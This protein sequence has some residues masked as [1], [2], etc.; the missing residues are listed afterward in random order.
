MNLILNILKNKAKQNLIINF[1]LGILLT[2][3]QLHISITYVYKQPLSL[4]IVFSISQIISIYLIISTILQNITIKKLNNKLSE[5]E[6]YNNLLLTSNDNIR[7]FKHDFNNIIQAIGGYIE[8]ND[9]TGLRKYYSELFSDCNNLNNLSVLNPKTIN[10]PAIY[11]VLS[12]KYLKANEL[13][14]QVNLIV[15]LN[16]NKLNMKVYEFTR[17]LGILL[18]NAIEAS[19]NSNEKIINIEIRNDFKVKRQILVIENTYSNKNVDTVKIFDKNY[20]SKIDNKK[21]HGLGLWEV[22]QILK[23]NNNLNLFTSKNNCFFKQQLEIY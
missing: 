17:I 3:I 10:N 21:S 5:T 15:F 19:L 1:M 14:I 18:D 13:G 6:L 9:L 12:S 20:T 2:I 7:G 8:T 16:L 4:I 11:Q 23:K 22:R